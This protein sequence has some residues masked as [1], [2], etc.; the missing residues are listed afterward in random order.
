MN[1][2]D[3][4][5]TMKLELT[6]GCNLRCR[7]CGIQGI[8][9]KAGGPYKYMTIDTATRIASQMQ[10]ANWNSKI[11]FAMRGEPLMNPNAVEIV[12]I[13]RK[14]LPNT[15]IMLTSNSL[16]LLK[17]KGVAENV[18][19]LFNAGLNIMALDAYKAS[20]KAIEKVRVFGNQSNSI[21]MYDYIDGENRAS[22]YTRVKPTA[23]RIFIMQD[24]EEV[25]MSGNKV[26]T[27]VG[28]NHAGVGLPPLE[29]PLVARCAR[30]FREMTIYHD[31]SVP[32]CCNDWRGK[33]MCGDLNNQDILDIWDG[34]ILNAARVHL[35]AR[36]RNF[37]PCDV[38][39]NKSFRVG[40]LPDKLGKE[41]MPPTSAE[42]RT[43]VLNVGEAKPHTTPVLREWEV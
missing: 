31:G 12:S 38:C 43:I 14:H 34:P 8:R 35:Y 2:Q 30:P 23:R 5:N 17:G 25:I 7:M 11:E 4:P 16:P 15:H 39:S 13:F 28:S 27:K 36:D 26:G 24:M 9:E 41:T 10:K 20:T 40:L 6:E 42:T 18:T 22:P 33:F 37:R 3:I 19:A 1:K 21:D 29:E 32:L